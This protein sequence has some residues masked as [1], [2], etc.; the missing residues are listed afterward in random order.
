M[1]GHGKPRGSSTPNH[2]LNGI[3]GKII[4]DNK[5][6]AEIVLCNIKVVIEREEFCLSGTNVVTTR[7]K[8]TRGMGSFK[9]MRVWDRFLGHKL[10]LQAG[11]DSPFMMRLTIEDPSVTQMETSDVDGSQKNYSVEKNSTSEFILP[12]CYFTGDNPVANWL[13]VDH[14]SE[15]YNFVFDDSLIIPVKKALDPRDVVPYT[16]IN[17][18]DMIDDSRQPGTAF[19]GY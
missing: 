6:V 19:P 8:K 12:I 1:D 15:T 18:D 17:T 9:I 14:V 4:I 13:F 5:E 16:G 11:I 2:P 3:F 10:T 7:M